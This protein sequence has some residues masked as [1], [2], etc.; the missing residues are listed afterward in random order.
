MNKERCLQGDYCKCTLVAPLCNLNFLWL[1]PII[2]L[3]NAL[4]TDQISLASLCRCL[5]LYR[6]PKKSCPFLFNEAC[7]SKL[8]ET[9]WT[10]SIHAAVCP[11][12]LAHIYVVSC[13]IK[14]DKTS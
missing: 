14:M 3:D 10:H 8:S 1:F 5:Y 2:D 6:M 12:S 9:S 7:Y 4:N 13:I 11:R